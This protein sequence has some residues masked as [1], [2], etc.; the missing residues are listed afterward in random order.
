[1]KSE[2]TSFKTMWFSHPGVPWEE[3]T[4]Q[5]TQYSV[6]FARELPSGVHN[7]VP[8]G[9]LTELAYWI[10]IFH[11]L[12]K[13]TRYFQEYIGSENPIKSELSRHSLLSAVVAFWVVR[14]WLAGYSICKGS[15]NLLSSVVF[16]VI[17]SHHGNLT[18]P[19]QAALL[20]PDVAERLQEQ[21]HSIHRNTLENLWKALK[22]PMS[23]EEIDINISGLPNSFRPKRF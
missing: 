1:M 22:I 2:F 6:Q 18:N 12:G 9:L 7:L 19:I 15:E 21:W 20:G 3:H 16:L 8:G 11:D 13:T 23:L 4:R 14:K 5:V 17:R 10:A